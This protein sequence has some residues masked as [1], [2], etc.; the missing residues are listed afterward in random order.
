MP[1]VIS[2]SRRTDIPAFFTPWLLHRLRAGFVMVR[3]PR[4]P[5]HVMRVSLAP[6]DVI[7]TVLWSRDYGRLLPHLDEIDDRGLRPCFQFTFTGYGPSLEARTPPWDR[8]HPQFELLAQRYGRQRVV[9]RYDPIVIGSEHH[10]GWHVDQFSRLAS[11]LSPSVSDAVISF[12]DLYP[13]ARNGLAAVHTMTGETFSPPLQ[14]E[15]IALAGR[16]VQAGAEA[17]IRVRAC[18]EP[19]LV[20]AGVIGAARCIDPEMIRAAAG[21]AAVELNDAPTRKGCGCVF[22]RD[23]GAY[24]CCAHGCVYCYA[25][26]SPEAGKANALQVHAHANHLGDGDIQQQAPPRKRKAPEQLELRGMMR[27]KPT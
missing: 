9:W 26:E 19:D 4:N 22:A 18:C 24:H 17:G 14:Q 23:I 27:R 6:E 7:A 12:L 20:Q 3:N 15:R 13:S 2:A 11:I 1:T 8:V 16:L 5:L 21:N 10:A 25:N